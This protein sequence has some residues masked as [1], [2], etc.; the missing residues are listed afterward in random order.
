VAVKQLEHVGLG[1]KLDVFPTRLSGGQQQRM[2]I[3]RALAMAPD[4]MLFDE[5]TSALDP[6][7]VGEVLDTMR[8][9]ADEGMTMILVTHELGF[10]RQASSRI[11]FLEQGRIVEEG[12]TQQIF[13]APQTETLRRALAAALGVAQ[14]QMDLIDLRRAN[15]A[16]RASVAQHG[17]PL[18][19]GNPRGWYAFLRRTW[20]ELE[21][22]AAERQ[23]G[24]YAL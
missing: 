18:W 22:F 8:L 20:R 10:A 19:I 1:A 16:M 24:L 7:L 2:A 23:R 4:Y 9:L 15:L 5:A 12:S 6:Q 11:A 14:A 21:D 17:R 13:D 3:A